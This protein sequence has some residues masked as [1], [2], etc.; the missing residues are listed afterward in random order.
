SDAQL[1]HRP[2]GHLP[3]ALMTGSTELSLTR[4]RLL[5]AAAVAS[6]A[7]AGL[8]LLEGAGAASSGVAAHLR[9]ASFAPLTGQTLA[10]SVGSLRLDEVADVADTALAGRDDVFVLRLSGPGGPALE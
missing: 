10:S 5:Q 6:V 8:D 3:V 1:L 9:R 2:P 7:V 4:R